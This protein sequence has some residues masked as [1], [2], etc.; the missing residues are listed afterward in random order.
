MTKREQTAGTGRENKA[1]Q[2]E[3]RNEY[4]T[5]GQTLEALGLRSDV[6]SSNNF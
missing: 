4:D 2:A 1:L 5:V 6:A 3:L